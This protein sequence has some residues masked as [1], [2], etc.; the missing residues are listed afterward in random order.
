MP[1]YCNQSR[2]VLD[3]KADTHAQET[4]NSGLDFR[5]LDWK[6]TRAI[7]V[8]ERD[9]QERMKHLRVP[10]WEAE[11]PQHSGREK[12]PSLFHGTQ[13]LVSDSTLY[14]PDSSLACVMAFSTCHGEDPQDLKSG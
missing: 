7:L 10:S 3:L 8:E 14:L 2:T 5:K 13:C 6:S 9:G 1:W 4:A 11:V 12:S